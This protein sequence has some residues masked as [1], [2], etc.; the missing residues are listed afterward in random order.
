[1]YVA[2]HITHISDIRCVPA[3]Y[4]LIETFSAGKHIT[5]T[6]HIGCVPT[7]YILV[8]S[9]EIFIGRLSNLINPPWIKNIPHICNQ[10]GYYFA[11]IMSIFYHI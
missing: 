4:V 1:M 3:A 2:K 10:R 9:L 8:E 7:A 11:D 5:H 6:S